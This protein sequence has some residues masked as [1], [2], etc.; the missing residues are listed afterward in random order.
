MN[1]ELRKHITSIL[2]EVLNI[3]ISPTDNLWRSQIANW[4]SLNHLELIF[5][6]EEE[7]KIR[8]T[9]KEVAEI[10]NVDDLVKIIGVK[11]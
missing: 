6:L 10:Q 8:F 7:F 1:D 4:D 5:L 11:M 9:I 2:S 3:G